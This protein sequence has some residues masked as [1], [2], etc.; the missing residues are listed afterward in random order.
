M[1][2]WP[3]RNIV[4]ILGCNTLVNETEELMECWDVV[5]NLKNLECFHN[6]TPLPQH[7]V[8]SLGG[9]C[10]RVLKV[11]PCIYKVLEDMAVTLCALYNDLHFVTSTHK[12]SLCF[13]Q[14]L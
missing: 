6:C 2:V 11:V 9:S 14:A 8:D 12:K 1:T 3:H 13:Y 7:P 4:G 5:N 10:E